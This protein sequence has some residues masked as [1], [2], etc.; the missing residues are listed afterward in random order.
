MRVADIR[1]RE[2]VKAIKFE[3]HLTAPT[4]ELEF[5]SEKFDSERKKKIMEKKNLVFKPK[6]EDFPSLFW[7]KL[8]LKRPISYNL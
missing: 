8:L 4:N 2:L 1:S 3:E 6:E 5:L 7:I